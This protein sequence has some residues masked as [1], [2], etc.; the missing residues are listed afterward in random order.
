MQIPRF[1][2]LRP[3]EGQQFRVFG[4]EMTYK[5]TAKDTDGRF[6]V[7]LETTA[8]HAGI[9]LH[10]HHNEDE[11]M[12]ILEG[13][14]QIECGGQAVRAGAGTFVLLPKDVPN[15]YENIGETPGTFLYVT[16]PAGFEK[17]VEE[18]S[19]EMSSGK[20]D[21]QKAIAAARVRGIDFL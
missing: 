17:V 7:A 15:R 1:K 11:A 4:S 14:F 13:E 12:Y 5:V 16:S 19:S 2:V 8:P 6:S 9:P 20:G 3:G 18:T 21:M 10:V